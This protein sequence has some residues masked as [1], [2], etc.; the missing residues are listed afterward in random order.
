MYLRHNS[1]YLDQI[2]SVLCVYKKKVTY[3]T[4]SNLHVHNYGNYIFL[5]NGDG[6]VFA[7]NPMENL[8]HIMSNL[9]GYSSKQYITLCNEVV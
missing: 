7:G 4:I 1:F 3:D 2:Y 6:V 9:F 8:I 5:Q